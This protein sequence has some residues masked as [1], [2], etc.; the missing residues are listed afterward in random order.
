MNFYRDLFYQFVQSSSENHDH[1][2][3]PL[4]PS[5]L[6]RQ[7]EGQPCSPNLAKQK[8]KK[9]WRNN[10]DNSLNSKDKEITWITQVPP[11][12]ERQLSIIFCPLLIE[13]WTQNTKLQTFRCQ[14][15]KPKKQCK[16]QCPYFKMWNRADLHRLKESSSSTCLRSPEG[17]SRRSYLLKGEIL[18]SSYTE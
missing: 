16:K 7:L 14:A 10:L 5:H 3:D 15:V 13:D 18:R 2:H 1:L 8:V 4:H 12:P 9:T 6:Y 17:I 11:T